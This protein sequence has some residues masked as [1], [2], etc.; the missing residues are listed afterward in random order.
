[1]PILKP[2]AAETKPPATPPAP[3][4]EAAKEEAPVRKVLYPKYDFQLA[5]G[6]KA[7]D[8]TTAKKLLGWKELPEGAT[9]GYT[10]V[11]RNGKKVRLENNITN[12]PWYSSVT[13]GLL[14][15]IKRK[16]WRFNF[17]PV[18]IGKTG[19]VLNGQHTLI[20]A[21]FAEQ[22][23]AKN[24]AHWS[25]WWEEAPTIDK[26]VAFGA[27]E[28]DDV[29]NTMDTCK[30]RS[31]ADVL[32]RSKFFRDMK[33]DVRKVASRMTEWAIKFL[34]L[35]TGVDADAY[36]PKMNHSEAVDFLNRH[37]R[38]L[39]CVKHIMEENSKGAISKYF[40]PGMAAGVLY[41][42][43]SAT[44]DVDVY[45]PMTSPDESVLDWELWDKATDFWVLLGSGGK[46]LHELRMA[47]GA[48]GGEEADS[49]PSA[50]EKLVVLAKAWKFFSVGDAFKA[51]ELTPAYHTDQDGIKILAE[52]P[53][54][55]GIDVGEAVA[56]PP[57]PPQTQEEIEAAKV[58]AEKEKADK[59]AEKEAEKTKKEAEKEA[60]RKLKAD[61]TL[62]DREAKAQAKKDREAQDVPPPKATEE[63]PEPAP[64]APT[65]APKPVARK[66]VGTPAPTKP[67]GK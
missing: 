60:A 28:D 7:L 19:L 52:C 63:T 56:P 58:A 61:A 48:L 46:E 50:R 54:F 55:G 30:P 25:Q 3:P 1:M 31:L 26:G 66:P 16:R 27:D 15:K 57:P 37:E 11:D 35:R 47:M 20:A 65:P 17:E 59:L 10:L 4:Q 32:Y 13:M 5:I 21:V 39:E 40:S 9:D 51:E 45:R 44:S 62:R 64:P 23:Y 67:K 6:P 42:M 24:T 36:A 2:K 22:E 41:L 38:I 49:V 53:I 18:I 34:W 29:V 14:E 33:A 8:A 12:R 43:G